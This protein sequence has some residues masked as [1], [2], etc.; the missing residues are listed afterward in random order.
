MVRSRFTQCRRRSLLKLSVYLIIMNYVSNITYN[1]LSLDTEPHLLLFS[2][3]LF[4]IRVDST[5]CVFIK[6]FTL[7]D[8]FRFF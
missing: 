2:Y 7:P 3:L 1:L 5:S 8:I 4:G 6:C